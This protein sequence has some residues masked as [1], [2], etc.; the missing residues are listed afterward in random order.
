MMRKPSISVSIFA[1]RLIPIAIWN[2]F[3]QWAQQR[4]LFTGSHEW[5][6]VGTGGLCVSRR[7][8]TLNPSTDEHDPNSFSVIA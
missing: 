6:P 4:P 3:Q 5:A 7:H 8:L 2:A 1:F